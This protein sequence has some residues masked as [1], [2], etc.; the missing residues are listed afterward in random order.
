MLI[1]Q[2]YN[3]TLFE[4]LSK[5]AAKVQQIFGIRKLWD[6]KVKFIIKWYSFV[7]LVLVLVLVLVFIVVVGYYYYFKFLSSINPNFVN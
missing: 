4:S 2:S 7:F 1:S 6:K 5:S 3:P